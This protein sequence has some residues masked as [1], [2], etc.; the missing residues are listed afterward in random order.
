MNSID[1]SSRSQ[2]HQRF[3][4]PQEVW[5]GHYRN[6][7]QRHGP[8]AVLDRV[9]IQNP[10]RPPAVTPGNATSN[11]FTASDRRPDVRPYPGHD[12]SGRVPLRRRLEER[13]IEITDEP[14]LKEWLG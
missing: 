1:R 7:D 10:P 2:S 8:H 9:R 11:W 3:K 6:A 12:P 13:S 5:I 14:A 4:C